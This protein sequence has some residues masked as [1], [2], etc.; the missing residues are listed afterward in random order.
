MHFLL[1]SVREHVCAHRFGGFNRETGVT[2]SH[3][4]SPRRAAAHD[5]VR[6]ACRLLIVGRHDA[7]K[8]IDYIGDTEKSH[9]SIVT[10]ARRESYPLLSRCRKTTPTVFRVIS[11]ELERARAR[12]QTL[13]K[14]CIKITVI[15][16][17]SRGTLSFR[18]SP[19]VCHPTNNR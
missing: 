16:P 4:I 2:R 15:L 10:G 1:A 6:N 9:E 12:A 7:P 17:F 19:V 18:R 13:R 14:K 5:R 3:K 11:R 8:D